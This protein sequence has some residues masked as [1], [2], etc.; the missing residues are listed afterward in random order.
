MKLLRWPAGLLLLALWVVYLTALVPAL[1]AWALL[2]GAAVWAVILH[3]RIGS[4]RTSLAGQRR[5]TMES[6]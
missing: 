2:S 5:D 3:R 1:P 6:T 4:V